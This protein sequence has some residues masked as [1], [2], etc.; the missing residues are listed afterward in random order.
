MNERMRN[1]LIITDLFY[2]SPRIPGL[3]KYL[4]DFG[5]KATIL[6]APLGN[7]NRE[8]LV[9]PTD[10]AEIFEVP[11]KGMIN[12]C[13]GMMG[14]KH[15]Q[16]V[17]A[18]LGQ[19]FLSAREETLMESVLFKLFIWGATLFAYPDEM[20]GWRLP[21]IAAGKKLLQEGKFDAILSSSFPVTSHLIACN[22]SRSLN[23]PWVADLRDLWTQN[24]NYL[25]PK[26]KLIETR[27]E[28]KTLH[29]ADALSTVSNSLAK[30]LQDRY[31]NKYMCVIPNGFDSALI[32]D[33]CAPLTS[34]FT[35]TY[36][37]LVYRGKQNPGRL[38]QALHDLFEEGKLDY[39]KVKV[40]FYGVV[41]K[42]IAQL[43]KLFGLE[44]I[45]VQHGPVLRDDVI[46]RQRESQVLL[47]CG[48]EEEYETGVLPLKMF[49]YF[50]ARRPII[51]TGGT[52]NEQFRNI[53]AQTKAGHD[54]ITLDDIKHILY[55]YYCSFLTS[56]AVAYQGIPSEMDKYNHYEMAK[57]FTHA[58]NQV[59][60]TRNQLN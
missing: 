33:P 45:V 15:N 48:W 26:R 60:L 28:K 13:K 37:G 30:K 50:A 27:L 5:W 8:R 18:Q 38:F 46:A 4:A 54:G 25:Y 32:N 1:V 41:Q 7:T 23:I 47:L 6:T 31:E 44:E 40:R 29:H 55:E 35:I 56:G 20:R 10:D 22:L 58:L 34:E 3:C 59:V 24:H 19:K 53:L 51:A 2:A 49:E 14:L 21:A 12:I 9:V 43:T 36:T 11:Y 17:F 39:R 42:W 57:K 52:P 16:S